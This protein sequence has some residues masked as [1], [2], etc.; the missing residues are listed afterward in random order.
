[1]SRP[2]PTNGSPADEN[3]DVW[4]LAGQ[5]NMQGC[6]WLEGA[7]TPDPRVWSFT[8]AGRWARAEEPLHKLWESFTPVHQDLMRRWMP[9]KD[10][11]I[12]DAEWARRESESRTRGAGLGLSFGKAL[13]DGR[14]RKIFADSTYA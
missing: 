5:S 1:M 2:S 12:G 11:K 14:Y 7:L 8:S 9:E 4:V 6:A 3:H 13:A 10:R